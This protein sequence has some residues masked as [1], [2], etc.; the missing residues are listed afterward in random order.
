VTTLSYSCAPTL[1]VVQWARHSINAPDGNNVNFVVQ[2]LFSVSEQAAISILT[3][4][5]TMTTAR[6]SSPFGVSEVNKYSQTFRIVKTWLADGNTAT[7]LSYS[8]G[9]A[10]LLFTEFRMVS[11]PSGTSPSNVYIVAGV[12]SDA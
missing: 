5:I 2:P 10:L 9:A 7:E 4:A 1:G 8:L 3:N 12:K 6:T 11:D